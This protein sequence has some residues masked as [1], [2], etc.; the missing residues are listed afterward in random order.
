MSPLHGLR[1]A[2]QGSSVFVT[3]SGDTG[4]LDIWDMRT[5]EGGVVRE[6]GGGGR[7]GGGGGRGRGG[8]RGEGR[9][10]TDPEL[11]QT[12]KLQ[13]MKTDFRTEAKKIA[14]MFKDSQNADSSYTV[15]DPPETMGKVQFALAV[16]SEAYPDSRHAVCGADS[17]ALYETR[18]LRRPFME[19]RVTSSSSDVVL[20]NRFTRSQESLCIKVCINSC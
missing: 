5:T 18:D 1:F 17:L 3:C 15:V 8:G 11:F 2:G 20:R 13:D 6:G 14:R 7:G 9:K 16:S 12:Y 10:P 4:Q 19:C